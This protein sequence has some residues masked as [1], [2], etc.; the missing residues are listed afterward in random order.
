MLACACICACVCVC[1]CTV[2]VCL[3][4]SPGGHGGMCNHIAQH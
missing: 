3:P 1:V 4:R 2:R